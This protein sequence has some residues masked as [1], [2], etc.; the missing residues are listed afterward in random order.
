MALSLDAIII[1]SI[2]IQ[3]YRKIFKKLYKKSSC[4]S[5]STSSYSYATIMW[6]FYHMDRVRR[7]K[8]L[9]ACALSFFCSSVGTDFFPRFRINDNE[10]RLVPNDNKSVSI[11][12]GVKCSMISIEIHKQMRSLTLEYFSRKRCMHK[13]Y[14][15]VFW[16][17]RRYLF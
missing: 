7:N 3:S 8:V 11:H 2:Q 4:P 17:V 14:M 16:V 5:S 6:N 9:K 10:I 12:Q 1:L 13:D 15:F